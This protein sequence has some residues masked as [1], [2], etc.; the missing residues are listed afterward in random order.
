MQR[1]RF[2]IA[3]SQGPSSATGHRECYHNAVVNC[4][5]DGPLAKELSFGSSRDCTC[6]IS[7]A[8]NP[9]NELQKQQSFVQF[10]SILPREL[11]DPET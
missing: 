6:C 9:G 5:E 3:S 4:S 1:I 11:Y 10:Q 7:R 2:Q 8:C